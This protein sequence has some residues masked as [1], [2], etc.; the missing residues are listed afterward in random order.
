MSAEACSCG[1]VLFV[2]IVVGL[3]VVILVTG[4]CNN[5]AACLHTLRVVNACFGV[6]KLVE[7]CVR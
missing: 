2:N 1:W 4:C 5:G 6:G 7:G 3:M